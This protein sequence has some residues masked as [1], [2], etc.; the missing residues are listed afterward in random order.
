MVH[1]RRFTSRAATRRQVL[2]FSGAGTVGAATALLAACQPGGAA[3]GTAAP[4][5]AD[6]TCRSKLEFFL[7]FAPG[8]LQHTALQQLGTDFAQ[9]R[10][11]CSVELVTTGGAADGTAE[12]LTTTLAAGTAPALVVM[13]PGTVT[14]WSARSLIAPVDDLYKRDRITTTDFP[15]PLWKQ[16][17]Y[18]GKVWFLPIFVNADFVMF[19]NKAHFRE[20]G[21]DPEKAPETIA[22]LD[23]A[24][25]KLTLDQGGDLKR[26]GMTPW[27][28]SNAGNTLQNWGYAFGGSFYDEAKDELTF[29]HPRIVRAVE[30]YTGWAR[31]LGTDRVDKLRKS[32]QLAPNTDFLGSGLQSMHPLTSP[33][34]RGTQAFAPTIELAGGPMPGEAPGKPGACTI[35]GQEICAVP[36]AKRAE[37]WDFMK[38]VALSDEGTK[39]IAN[40]VGIP[41]YLKSPSLND[42][43]KDPAQKVFVDA[44]KRAQ[45][46]QIGFY[47]PVNLNL[48]PI[49]E[50]IDGKRGV[51]DA[52]DTINTDVNRQL[53]DLKAQLAKK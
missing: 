6:S 31:T 34:V 10:S 50:V 25:Q 14:T 3:G 36:G 41:G 37:A 22:D 8:S 11:G 44:A 46:V 32:V 40:G 45:F 29:N 38:Y 7:P 39:V 47:A 21:L 27:L 20:I 35:G 23:K 43:S 49:Q 17:S 18:G 52:M 12:K 9:R 19:W 24:A 4:P 28:V 26:V 30:W 2:R 13:P 1:E 33:L 5:A 15:V 51:R 42:L 16:M 53:K 48:A